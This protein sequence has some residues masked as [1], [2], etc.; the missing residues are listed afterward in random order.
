VKFFSN[1]LIQFI[2]LR[3]A[4]KVKNSPQLIAD[5]KEVEIQ[6]NIR[7]ASFDSSSMYTNICAMYLR[8]IMENSLKLNSMEIRQTLEMLKIYDLLINKNYFSHEVNIL[9]QNEGLAMGAP[10]SATLLEI[11]LQYIEE[12][13]IIDILIDNKILGYFRCVDDTFIAYDQSVTDINS[14]S[15]EF[16]QIHQNLQYTIELEENKK[17]NFLDLTV[18]RINKIV[19]FNIYQKLTYTDAVIRYNPCHPSEHK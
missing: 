12:N 16:N 7:L 15:N 6:P 11:F 8:D 4:F 9:H 13:F 5:L 2:P 3:K 10:S 1:I 18:F 19:E 14:V 17:I